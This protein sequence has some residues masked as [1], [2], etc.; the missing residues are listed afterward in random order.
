MDG[1]LYAEL[2]QNR[3][4]QGTPE[5]P[6]TL[7]AYTPINGAILSVQNDT[8]SLS[9]AILNYMSVSG[10]SGRVGFANSGWWGIDV[11]VQSYTG[12]FYVKGSYNGTFTA[13]LSSATSNETFSSVDILSNSTNDRWTRHE[14]ELIP[15]KSAS[16]TNNTFSITFASVRRLTKPCQGSY[17]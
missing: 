4:F 9:E 5:V 11:Q 15:D 8:E 7:T 12:S 3:A 6:P 2:I 17:F 1:G 13:S 16:D 14:F 10:G